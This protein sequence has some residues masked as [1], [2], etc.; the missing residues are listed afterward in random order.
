[1][2]MGTAPQYPTRTPPSRNSLRFDWL[3][4]FFSNS[5]SFFLIPVVHF[6]WSEKGREARAKTERETV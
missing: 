2:E 5:N 3:T 6:P 1:M 4:L